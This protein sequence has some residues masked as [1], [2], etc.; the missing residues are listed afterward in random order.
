MP[1]L[2]TFRL[3]VPQIPVFDAAQS[4]Q[5]L[6]HQ[7]AIG[8]TLLVEEIANEAR[9][10][11]P[12]DTGILR[13]AI[14]TKVTQGVSATHLVQGEVFTGRQAPYALYVEEGTRPH[15]PPRAP[16][17]AWARRK[18]GDGRLW[19]VVARAI[20][21]RGTR[22]RHMFRD[23]LRIVQPKIEPTITAFVERAAQLLQGGR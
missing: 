5:I 13:G 21:R 22:A 10:R 4:Q 6:R 3:R 15:F 14:A 19:F 16:L 8:M 1:L 11:T 7:V 12:A 23:A 2:P 17:E 20:A 18:L 9:L